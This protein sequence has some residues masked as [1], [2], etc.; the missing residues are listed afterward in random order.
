MPRC[1]F[2]ECRKKAEIII[3]DCKHCNK[4]YCM[5]HRYPTIHQCSELKSAKQQIQ[6]DLKNKLNSEK[7]VQ[8]KL[9]RI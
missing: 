9:V 8:D 1:Q 5:T 6:E 7:C 4:K 2:A 3:G